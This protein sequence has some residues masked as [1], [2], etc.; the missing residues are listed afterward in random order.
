MSKE[1][2]DRFTQKT[3]W[4][5]RV[6]LD[7]PFEV[8]DNSHLCVLTAPDGYSIRSKIF[9]D[10]DHKELYDH[11]QITIKKEPVYRFVNTQSTEIAGIPVRLLRK[12]TCLEFKSDSATTGHKNYS[13][14]EKE[15]LLSGTRITAEITERCEKEKC[16][17]KT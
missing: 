6:T 14:L 13:I 12:G 16:K 15:L 1:Q 7:K 11:S 2:K 5:T 10:N 17:I 3:T 4:I 8:K 9:P